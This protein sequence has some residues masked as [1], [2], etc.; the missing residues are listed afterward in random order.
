MPEKTVDNVT[1]PDNGG[2]GKEVVLQMMS[3]AK[4][5]HRRFPLVVLCALLVLYAASAQLSIAQA[6]AQ[7]E[8]HIVVV[9]GEGAKNVAQQ[10]AA[11]QL[12]VRVLD[13][14]NRP[15]EGAAVTF[16]APASGP[17]ADFTNDSKSLRVLANTDGVANA[18]PYHP[19]AATGAYE[20]QIRAEF[21]RALATAT[22]SQMN[23]VQGKRHKKMITIIAIAGAAAGAAIAAHAR[24]SSSSSSSSPGGTTITFG[25][26]GIGVPK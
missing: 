16:S 5:R 15:V 20:I 19:N 4:E 13:A 1:R 11:K 26:S 14:N 9:E 17:S 3:K 25:G 12:I 18:G 7:A 24:S 2:S 23:V 21:R 10:I 22:I 8:L 6:T